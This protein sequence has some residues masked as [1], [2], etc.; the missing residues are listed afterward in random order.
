MKTTED[1]QTGEATGPSPGQLVDASKASM[2]RA[3]CILCVSFT[4][5]TCIHAYMQPQAPSRCRRTL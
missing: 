1:M 2:R 4:M 5:H 3:V